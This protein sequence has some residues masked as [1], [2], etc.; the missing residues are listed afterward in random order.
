LTD[1]CQEWAQKDKESEDGLTK[2]LKGALQSGC[3]QLVDSSRPLL[4]TVVAENTQ[5]Q[6]YLF[7]S[8]YRTELSVDEVIPVSG[9]IPGLQNYQLEAETL[10]IFRQLITFKAK[11]N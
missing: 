10:G 1:E 8:I 7:L 11:Q 9:A 6:N 4:R 2:F 5:R 3:P